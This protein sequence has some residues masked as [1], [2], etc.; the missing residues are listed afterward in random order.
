MLTYVLAVR[1]L[2]YNVESD[3]SD[4]SPTIFRTVTQQLTRFQLT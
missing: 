4:E 2:P 3:Y 1:L